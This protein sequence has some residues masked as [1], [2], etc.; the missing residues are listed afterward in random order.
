[1]KQQDLKLCPLCESPLVRESRNVTA[2]YKDKNLSYLQPGEWCSECGEG[3]F[4]QRIWHYQS[5][6]G[7]IKNEARIQHKFNISFD[8]MLQLILLVRR[9]V[10]ELYWKWNIY[11]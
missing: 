4:P 11:I 1:M 8:W 9:F 10:L 6:S 3:F 2:V 7:M 5:R